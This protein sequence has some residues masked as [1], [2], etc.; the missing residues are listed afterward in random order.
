LQALYQWQLTGQ[1]AHE[2]ERQ[3]VAEQDLARVDMDYFHELITQVPL[4]VAELDAVIAPLLDRPIPEVDPVER[5]ILRLGAY[6][7]A[8][9]LDVP[10]RVAINESIE[11]AKTFGAE[12]G[13]K[14]VN[15]ILDGVAKKV[16]AAEVAARG[17][18]T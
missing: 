5:A 15:S 7:L 1:S 14:Y 3:F 12:Q 17:K 11:L 10:Y 13:H 6:E 2:I 4:R 16:R 18:K 9:R 8:Y